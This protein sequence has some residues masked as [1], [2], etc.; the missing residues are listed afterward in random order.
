LASGGIRLLPLKTMKR[1][2]FTTTLI[3]GMGLAAA[4]AEDKTFTGEIMDRMCGQMQ[5]HEAM[6]KAESAKNA[7]ECTLAC[8]KNGDKFV[9][10]DSQNKKVYPLSDDPKVRQYAGQRVQVTG[11]Y[12]DGADMLSVKSISPA[13]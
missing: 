13:H 12:D 9:L 4:A 3:A 11:S 6:M 5:S 8:V 2:F 10:F 1:L 7:R